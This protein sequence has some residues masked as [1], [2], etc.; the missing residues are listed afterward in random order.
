MGRKKKE[1]QDVKGV[2]LEIRVTGEIAEALS[3][4]AKEC[5][6]NRSELVRRIVADAIGRHGG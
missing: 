6:V 4:I 5:A 1:P 2:T 3:K